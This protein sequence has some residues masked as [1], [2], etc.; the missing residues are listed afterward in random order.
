M[1]F[2]PPPTDMAVISF[3]TNPTPYWS[4]GPYLPPLYVMQPQPIPGSVLPA[5]QPIPH[6]PTVT[7]PVG[8]LAS[9]HAVGGGIPTFPQPIPFPKEP[10]LPRP[11]P[12]IPLPIGGDHH[13]AAVMV[14]PTAYHSTPSVVMFGG[15]GG[16]AF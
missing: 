1:M 3:Q 11:Q 14:M 16:G 4:S 13:A 7:P 15:G 12:P 10:T 6:P 9:F 5:V 2:H 8:Q